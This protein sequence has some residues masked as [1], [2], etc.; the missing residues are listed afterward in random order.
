MFTNLFKKECNHEWHTIEYSNVLQLDDMG[1]PLR[2]V[3]RKCSKCG[4]TDQHWRD[5]PKESLKQL[6]DGTSVLLEWYKI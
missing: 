5:V 4:K 6:D 3:I 1:Y 2:L